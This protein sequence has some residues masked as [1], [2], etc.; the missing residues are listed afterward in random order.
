M[1]LQQ[2]RYLTEI[3]KHRSISK[4]AEAL[5]V[6]QPTISKAIL[7]LEAEL[8]IRILERTNKGVS[9]TQQGKEALF[10]AR[11]LLE[12]ADAAVSHF[13]TN[14]SEGRER[15]SISSQHYG[16][17]V[18]AMSQWMTTFWVNLMRSS[19]EREKL[20]MSSMK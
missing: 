1:T 14:G 15:L 2:C 5:Y 19:C 7:E 11:M 16:F 18:E 3:S 8:G 6:T 17:V 20:L 12:Q 4:A 9:F 10:Y 13:R